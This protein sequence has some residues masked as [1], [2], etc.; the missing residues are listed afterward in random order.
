MKIAR[1]KFHILAMA[2]ICV[3][4]ALI[5]GCEMF[6]S[7][8]NP[9]PGWKSI[10]AVGCKNGKMTAEISPIPGYETIS[11]DV[12]EFVNKLPVDHLPDY[13]GGGTRR[14]CYW[15]QDMAFYEDGTGQHAVSFQIPH[16]GTWWRYVLIYDQNNKRVKAVRYVQGH[17]AC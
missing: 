8:T 2:S 3:S 4:V 9:I 17:Y 12:Q 14:W 1:V 7:H 15:I 13:V 10:R 6:A 5:T 11:D 16:D